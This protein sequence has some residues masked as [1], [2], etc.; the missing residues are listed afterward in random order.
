MP[1]YSKRL[2]I[3]LALI[4]AV[5]AAALAISTP[6]A[7]AATAGGPA[8]SAPCQQFVRVIDVSRWQG[9]ID[10]RAVQADQTAG[11]A[12][13][14]IK[15]GGADGGYY[16]DPQF[17]PNIFG[18]T[19]AGLPWGPYFFTNPRPGDGANQARYFV[20][21]GGGKGTLPA[22]VD[23]EYNTAGMTGAGIDAFVLDFNRTFTDLTGRVP[24]VYVG[25][26]F[27]GAGSDPRLAVYPLNVPAYLAGYRPNPDPCS[28]GRPALPNAWGGVGWS[29]WQFTSSALIGG[30]T[31]GHGVDESIVTPDAWA[32]WTGAAVVP[33]TKGPD[34]AVDGDQV[35]TIGSRGPK[36]GQI[37]RLVGATVDGE[38]GPNTAAAVAV[39]QR[40]LGLP[41]DGVW[42]PTTDAAATAFLAW[43]AALPPL[44]PAVV[45]VTH[46]G[47][48]RAPSAGLTVCLLQ[49]RLIDHGAG[50]F[51]MTR[52]CRF[53]PV[54]T[55]RVVA[56]QRSHGLTADGIV[57]PA[58]W[59]ELGE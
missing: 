11:V 26:F 27:A 19:A 48:V 25:A 55:A 42:G 23:V 37:Q 24:A 21:I 8:S 46:P 28:I 17:G 34:P 38:F 44:A 40:R 47:T 22:L 13:A 32:V 58:T 49:D 4:L 36:V 16:Q 2:I 57:G 15:A 5:L 43:L 30:I 6:P 18:A 39:F 33:N 1:N 50:G 31:P 12:G 41:A 9:S 29:A 59:S 45:P 51:G 7:H 52:D 14:W 20:S 54:T 53:G 10:W 3:A 56:F 35:F